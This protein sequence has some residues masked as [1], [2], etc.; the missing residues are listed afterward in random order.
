MVP[1][2]DPNEVNILKLRFLQFVSI[3]MDFKFFKNKGGQ[4]GDKKHSN[5]NIEL[6]DRLEGLRGLAYNTSSSC[7]LPKFIISPVSDV[8]C[9]SLET[10]QL[11][12]KII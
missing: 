5:K 1:N 11:D 10:H 7:K 4:K 8:L 3:D 12:S 9:K 2:S 6:K